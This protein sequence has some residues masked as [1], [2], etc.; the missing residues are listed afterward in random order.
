MAKDAPAFRL[1]GRIA[2]LATAMLTAG[3]AVFIATIREGRTFPTSV[4]SGW[5]AAFGVTLALMLGWSIA[6]T[7]LI[8]F[9]AR[10]RLDDVTSRHM[11]THLPLLIPTGMAVAAYQSDEANHVLTQSSQI[12]WLWGLA[13]G[14]WIVGQA[15]WLPAGLDAQPIRVL[16][17]LK[18]G[19]RT[20][21]AS[22]FTRLTFGLIFVQF[23]LFR[24]L[25]AIFWQPI[26]FFERGSDVGAYEQRARLVTQGLYPY[27]D[28][29]VE[30]PPLFPWLASG[31][32]LLST[33]FGGTDAAFQLIFS[34]TMLPFEAGTLCLI[35]A[36][37]HRVWDEPRGLM[38]A[39]TYAL[40]FYPAYIANRHF[41]SIPVFFLLLG[42]YLIIMNRRHFA[43][44]ALALGILTKFF[45]L[46]GFPA[47]L[48]GQSRLGR[49]RL[50][51]LGGLAIAGGI[52][53]FFV[54]SR[55]YVV[56]S[57]QNML[58]R[59]G[60]ETI[61][62]LAD[63]YFSF[64]WVHRDRLNPDTAIAFN[65][66]P[67][68]PS[69]VWW[70]TVT[71]VAVIY[72]YISLR[73]V[74]PTAKSTVWGTG[75]AIVTFALFL[76]GWSPQFTVW[77][78]P[79]VVLA[80]PGGRGFLLATILTT[81]A[82]LESPGFF[83]LWSEQPFVLWAIVIFRTILFIA[84]GTMFARRLLALSRKPTDPSNTRTYD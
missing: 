41:E 81:V 74:T 76:R 49:V 84:I 70:G 48:T 34:F 15:L 22:A 25:L 26:G 39:L 38:S 57:I 28:Y 55:E 42:T 50:L 65:Y 62:A 58:L 44:L 43:S 19:L 37:G 45:P 16:E 14:S 64:G 36:I 73:P 80:Y 78:L 68:I 61:W 6:G 32:K 59:P 31:L 5:L 1:R 51:G 56:A 47:L 54:V 2:I 9:T 29:W 17:L 67:D 75:L 52:I 79:F 83:Y 23:V 21:G 7:T 8:S 33:N 27:L 53:P 63:G 10:R 24:S 60:W 30:Y 20:I 35:Y 69:Y 13:L 71:V 40:L 66:I 77:V 12:D 18:S 82:L 11:W 46:A 72:G 3:F 4:S